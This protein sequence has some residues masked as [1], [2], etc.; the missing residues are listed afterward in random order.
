[1]L[2]NAQK[3]I[4]VSIWNDIDASE[5]MSTERLFAMTC[6]RAGEQLGVTVDDGDVAEALSRYGTTSPPRPTEAK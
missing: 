5:D 2:T 4:V 6:D 1:M 3:R